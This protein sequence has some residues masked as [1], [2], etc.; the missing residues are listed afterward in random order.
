M[1]KLSFDHSNH[2]EKDF[3]KLHVSFKPSA[4]KHGLQK[5]PDE[6][7]IKKQRTDSVKKIN[8]FFN[9]YEVGSITIPKDD[10]YDKFIKKVKENITH[11]EGVDFEDKKEEDA[12]KGVKIIKQKGISCVNAKGPISKDNFE[13]VVINNDRV[14]VST[15][16]FS[17]LKITDQFANEN[18][19]P[20]LLQELL[21]KY[22]ITKV[23]IY[24]KEI[25]DDG[26]KHISKTLEGLQSLEL[27]RCNKITDAGLGHISRNLEGLQS[28]ELMHCDEITDAGLKPISNKFE[29]LQRLEV[30]FC[31]NFRGEKVKHISNL[32][33]LF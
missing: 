4:P 33:N 31:K 3:N 6:S 22:N 16:D 7:T 27:F 10:T 21:N 25:T 30:D 23:D 13:S 2:L 11:N 20:T 12:Y 14:D 24:C 8:I 29:N 9:D 28:L 5:G 26:L 18:E 19:L 15:T 17:T 32:K 1:S